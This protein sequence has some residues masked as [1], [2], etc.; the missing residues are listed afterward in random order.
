[1]RTSYPA[2]A[3]TAVLACALAGPAAAQTTSP[4]LPAGSISGLP[5]VQ[6]NDNEVSAGTLHGG[7]L[8][9]ALE[10]LRADWR[11]ET[12]NGPGLRV[13]AVA[14]EGGAPTIPAPL[15]RAETGTRLR[16]RVR[17]RLDGAPI[18]VFGLHTRPA[19]DADPIEVDPGEVRTLELFA[20]RS[21]SRHE[22]LLG[23]G[24]RNRL[25]DWLGRGVRHQWPLVALYGA[26]GAQR[27]R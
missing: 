25:S 8:D 12:P 22:H 19:G 7:V 13:A 20:S 11:V 14:E 24:G 23:D 27:R 5:L 10:V 2:L 1:M 4:Y 9:L 3:A 18:T 21:N 6:P 16:I 15:I 26:H 17:N